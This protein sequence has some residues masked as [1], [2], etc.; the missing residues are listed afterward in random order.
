MRRRRGARS[1]S[2]FPRSVVT[3]CARGPS[4]SMGGSRMSSAAA[5]SACAGTTRFWPTSCSANG[6]PADAPHRSADLVR[7][8]SFAITAT[9][10]PVRRCGQTRLKFG[11]NTESE[12]APTL[13]RPWANRA[14]CRARTS[15]LAW[16]FLRRSES[17]RVL[18][19]ARDTESETR[20]HQ[21][22][23]CFMDDGT[24]P[25]GRRKSRRLRPNN[26]WNVRL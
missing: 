10:L 14:N 24:V 23:G 4:G 3:S 17:I 2:S 26:F 7:L 8:V 20:T 19:A 9:V 22:A 6:Q 13:I 16:V 5:M 25:G 12:A 21:G 18:Q 15:L 1:V 11:E